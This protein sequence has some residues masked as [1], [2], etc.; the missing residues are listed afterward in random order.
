MAGLNNLTL[1]K[2]P[3]YQYVKSNN[4]DAL[5]N[6]KVY[7]G[8]PN[9]DPTNPAN[10]IDVSAVQSGGSL[11]VLTQPIRTN[12]A[13]LLVDSVGNIVYPV[14]SPEYAITVRDQNDALVYEESCVTGPISGSGSGSGLFL[15]PKD[16]GATDAANSN[17]E[18]QAAYDQANTTGAS[19]YLSGT[20]RSDDS[21]NM[22][23]VHTTGP[24]TLDFTNA[25]SL[26]LDNSC[27]YAE[28]S[29]DNL[30]QPASDI[31][32]GSAKITMS[33]PP[34]LS[35]G[36]IIFIGSTEQFSNARAAYTKGEAPIVNVIVNNDI[37]VYGSIFD[38]YTAA[39]TTIFKLNPVSP[40]IDSGVTILAPNFR[41]AAGVKVKNGKNVN[42]R[43]T[44]IGAGTS[45]IEL[46]QCVDSSVDNAY[47]I[48]RRENI[49]TTTGTEY[50]LVIANCQRI[51]VTGSTLIGERHGLTTGGF[52]NDFPNGTVAIVCRET[53]FD[54]N[55]ISNDLLLSEHLTGGAAVESFD[56]HGNSEYVT[57]TGNVII[58][59]AIWAGNNGT[60][61]GNVVFG[62]NDN[63][64]SMFRCVEMQ[65]MDHNIEGNIFVA[66]IRN[67]PSS[68]DALF[69]NLPITYNNTGVSS[70]NALSHG[71]TFKFK[72]NICVCEDSNV[73]ANTKPHEITCRLESGFTGGKINL[74]FSGNTTRMPGTA[75]HTIG[76]RFI[77]LTNNVVTPAPMDMI[78]E[79][80]NEWVNCGGFR[81]DLET[82]TVQNSVVDFISYKDTYECNGFA[83]SAI[84]AENVQGTVSIENHIVKG[85]NK[86]PFTVFSPNLTVKD[87]NT[88]PDSITIKGNEIFDSIKTGTSSSERTI[89]LIQGGGNIFV[90]DNT[91]HTATGS[92]ILDL[93][94]IQT[95]IAS[96]VYRMDNIDT[97]G[98]V[99]YQLNYFAGTDDNF[100]ETYYK[101]SA[102]QAASFVAR[103]NE[104]FR[105]NTTSGAININTPA[106]ADSPDGTMFA[107]WDVGGSLDSNNATL[108]YNG[109][110]TIMGGA[111]NYVLSGNFSNYVFELVDGDWRITSNTASSGGSSGPQVGI[112]DSAGSSV[113]LPV[114][115]GSSRQSAGSYT[116]TFPAK[117]N[118]DYVVL[119]T[120]NNI[121][122][123]RFIVIHSKTTTQFEVIVYDNGGTGADSGFQF[124]VT[125]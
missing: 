43:C 59:G 81:L 4:G 1:L 19:I 32:K 11:T 114:G 117:A 79:F 36:D 85:V 65:G 46:Q 91:N 6:A 69:L 54:N 108:I 83:E 110:H 122:S 82:D 123:A 78:K 31:V 50:G 63:Q 3:Y 44:T 101:W 12:A 115:W 29:V 113:R 35:N 15:D 41:F 62:A 56:L 60:F 8:S 17:I 107:V 2:L 16:F 14:T 124:Q 20:Y 77:A 52:L 71:G 98:V 99:S 100:H 104:R 116:V 118:T 48:E 24:G 25:T 106:V 27:M 80:D 86:N 72:N 30:G 13:G 94:F 21:I 53:V 95:F 66:R 92:N 51:N 88:M 90:E 7:V 9:A 74:E 105:I 84:I 61:K 102:I 23:S 87:S 120:P 40:S 119:A 73:L 97:D 49:D 70:R 89:A 33:S 93:A 125:D 38:D 109:T 58:N 26:S 55:F 103:A 64:N 112:V 67:N 39:S 5:F 42:I 37:D 45:G 57:C 22:H 47:S 96:K 18:I 34:A 121:T 75:L 76:F 28:G 10:Q 68:N 111:S